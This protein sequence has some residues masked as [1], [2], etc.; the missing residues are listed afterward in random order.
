MN[1]KALKERI[2]SI[3]AE[4]IRLFPDEFQRFKTSTAERRGHLINKW[5]EM[6]GA[7]SI[8]RHLFDMPEKLYQALNHNLTRDE[9]DWLFANGAFVKD[10]RGTEWFM[11]TF[12]EFLITDSY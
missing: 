10:F 9:F 3:I 12:K 1:K 5:G 4:Y 6:K 8:E 11:K 2:T 7:D